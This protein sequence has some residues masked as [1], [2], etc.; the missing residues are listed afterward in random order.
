MVEVYQKYTVSIPKKAVASVK[1][2]KKRQNKV[3]MNL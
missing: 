3:K 2:K 1:G